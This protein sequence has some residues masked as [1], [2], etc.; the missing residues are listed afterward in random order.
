MLTDALGAGRAAVRLHEG[1]LREGVESSMILEHKKQSDTKHRSPRS[2]MNRIGGRLL[3]R[4]AA[5]PKYRYRR[6]IR[7]W[8]LNVAP[9]GTYKRILSQ[10]P[11][12]VNLHWL[13]EGFFPLRSITRLP[14]HVVWTLHDMW[15]FTGGCHYDQGCGRYETGCGQCP[16]LGSSTVGDLSHWSL[17]GKRKAVGAKPVTVVAPSRWL[18]DCARSS[19]LFRKCRVERIPYGL[20]LERFQVCDQES[21]RRALGLPIRKRIV[22]FGAVDASDPRKGFHYLESALRQLG[23]NATSNDL[24]LLAFGSAPSDGFAGM[25]LPFTSLGK[26]SNDRDLALAYSAADVFVAPSVQDNL[27]NTVLESL[28]CGTPVVAFELGGFVDMIDHLETGYLAE[29]LSR[30]GL[31]RGIDW[32]IQNPDRNRT[33]SRNCRT[34]AETSYALHTQARRYAELYQSLG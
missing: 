25:T 8:S 28:A 29:P 1:L 34:K 6:D 17:R 27:P 26:V 24:H 33:L 21:A 9:R 20:D 15:A 14:C 30:Q 18:A 3:A 22:L 10:N 5:I 31:A 23:E 7:N 16:Q 13:G 2:E 4:L 12:V 32:C 11:D 19:L